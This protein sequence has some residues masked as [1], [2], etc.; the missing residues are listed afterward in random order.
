VEL[1]VSRKGRAGE[2]GFTL[3]EVLIAILIAM[4]GLLGT[5]AV[6]HSAMNAAANVSDAQTA[7]RLGTSTLEQFNA[8]RTQLNPFVD[9]LGSIATGDWTTPIFM[10][11]QNRSST[12][13]SPAHRWQ[14]KTRVVNLGITRPYNISVEVVYALD[15]GLAKTVQLDVE[16]RKTW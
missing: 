14:I 15:S 11:V 4:V 3:I 13:W 16:R 6:Q 9:M 7:M 1:T 12:V 5:V 10:D 2:A 8:R